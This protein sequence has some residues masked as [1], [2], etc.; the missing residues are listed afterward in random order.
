MP[1]GRQVEHRMQVGMTRGSGFVV[2]QGAAKGG[3]WVQE[4][5]TDRCSAMHR[6]LCRICAGTATQREKS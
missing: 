5:S 1:G 3:S 2:R 4:L 6:S